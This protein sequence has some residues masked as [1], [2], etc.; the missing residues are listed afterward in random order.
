M[1]LV[2]RQ[3]GEERVRLGD[4]ADVELSAESTQIKTLSSGRDAVFMSV[5]PTPDANPLEV[6]RAVHGAI[7][8]IAAA[9]PADM[10][11]FLDWDGS[12]VIDEALGEVV[13]TLLEASLI[14]ILVI[15]LFL[16]SIRVVLIPLVAIP[17]SLIGVVFLILAMGFSH[18]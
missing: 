13:R 2:V 6:S 14:V 4:V 15:Y 18:G 1:T 3:A 11:M 7:P 17:L 10:K 9:L 16:G 5:T 8:G 12:V